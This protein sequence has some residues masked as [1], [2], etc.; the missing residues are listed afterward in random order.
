M[1][2]FC[3]FFDKNYLSR[4]LVL[5]N[6]LKNC[7]DFFCLYVLC[8]D[9]FTKDY[10]DE[11]YRNDK[12]IITISFIDFENEN[13]DFFKVKENRTLIEYY[14]TLSPCLP[15][16][17]IEKFNLPHICSLDADIKFYNSPNEIFDLL[18]NYSIIITPHKFS[19]ENKFME[20]WGKHNVSFQVFKNDAVGIKCLKLW[21]EQCLDWCKDVLDEVN[22]RF[23]DQKY[24]DNWTE[25]YDGN[26]KVLTDDVSGL[27]PWNLNKFEIK[28][29]NKNFTSNNKKIIFYHFH[30]NKF[31]N[32]YWATTGFHTYNVNFQKEVKKLYLNYWNEVNK[33]SNKINFIQDNSVRT[34]LNKDL[35]VNLMKEGTVFF[36]ISNFVCFYIN[37][38][39]IHPFIRKVLLKIYA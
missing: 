5:I 35:K 1:N 38:N 21:K 8:L 10:L 29:V 19:D 28:G 37:L 27:A 3:T 24:L 14:F 18:E 11:N 31:L 17:L 22:N 7:E 33:M 32:K 39:S 4:G 30:H 20:K 25:E 23:A 15:L 12:D 16:Y 26:I 34:V 9:V 36:R 13:K 2:I 6:S